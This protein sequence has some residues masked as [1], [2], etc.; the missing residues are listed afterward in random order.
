M[1]YTIKGVAVVAAHK[2]KSTKRNKLD[3]M[4]ETKSVT[5]SNNWWGNLI[6]TMQ[7]QS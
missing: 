2:H 3:G 1:E 7:C 6:S 5:T 4:G